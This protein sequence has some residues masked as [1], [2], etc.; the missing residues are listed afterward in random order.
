MRMAAFSRILSASQ[1][2]SM[3]LIAVLQAGCSSLPTINP[4]DW[5]GGTPGPKMAELQDVRS[6]VPLRQ[7]EYPP[8]RSL[9]RS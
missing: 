8:T 9:R 5:W 4:M 7:W 3:A 1:F 6:S 2:I